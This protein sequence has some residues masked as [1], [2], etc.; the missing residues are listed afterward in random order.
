M[1][2][3]GDEKRRAQGRGDEEKKLVEERRSDTRVRSLVVTHRSIETRQQRQQRQHEELQRQQQQQPA[4]SATVRSGYH[5]NQSSAS[6]T[7][8]NNIINNININNN[9]NSLF[10]RTS[11]R[12]SHHSLNQSVRLKRNNCSQGSA[13]EFGDF[14]VHQTGFHSDSPSVNRSTSERSSLTIN[15][16]ALTHHAMQ[17][18]HFMVPVLSGSV[19]QSVQIQFSS[20]LPEGQGP[21]M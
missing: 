4:G 10:R 9:N 14:D 3:R 7:N 1:T 13:E 19:S 18:K 21:V 8:H 5:G 16:A 2:R 6:I 17:L 12:L 15:F 20:D 11:A